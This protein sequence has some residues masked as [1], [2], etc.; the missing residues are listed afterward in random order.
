MKNVMI[1]AVALL[2]MG[3]T[4]CKR[5]WTCTCTDGS[6]DEQSTDILNQSKSDA[7]DICSSFESGSQTC[8]LEKK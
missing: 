1:I 2:M 5:D 7:E 8:D 6:G 3:L 4:A